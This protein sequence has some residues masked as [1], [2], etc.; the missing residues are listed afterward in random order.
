MSAQRDQ[1]ARKRN[2]DVPPLSENSDLPNKAYPIAGFKS[3]LHS[4]VALKEKELR[5]KFS[6]DQDL[7]RHKLER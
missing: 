3:R 6:R 1:Y 2:F 5:D 4:E 7:K